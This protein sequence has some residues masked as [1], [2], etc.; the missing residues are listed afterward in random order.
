MMNVELIS[1]SFKTFITEKKSDVDATVIFDLY[2]DNNIRDE[3]EDFISEQV[4]L[5]GERLLNDGKYFELVSITSQVV[6]SPID[7]IYIFSLELEDEDIFDDE[8]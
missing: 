6:P 1:F 4:K 2:S 8:E 3:F 7:I 5:F